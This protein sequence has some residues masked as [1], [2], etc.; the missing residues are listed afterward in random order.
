MK[1]I[2]DTN[3]LLDVVLKRKPFEDDSLIVVEA[4]QQEL[5]LGAVTTQTIADMFYLLRK[6]FTVE[7]RKTLLLWYCDI[8]YIAPIDEDKVVSALNNNDFTDFE[9]CLQAECA[10]TFEA[11][12]IV[13]RNTKHFFHSHVPAITPIEFRAKLS[14]EGE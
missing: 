12:Y 1:I 8:F 2:V 5:V 3:V 4:C 6:H 11:D 9:D 7:E 10:I 13:T 14:V